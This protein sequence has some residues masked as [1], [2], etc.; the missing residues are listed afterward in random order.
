MD[1]DGYVETFDVIIDSDD[2]KAI[3][4]KEIQDFSTNM[5]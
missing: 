5:V 1:E 3:E 2:S 4:N